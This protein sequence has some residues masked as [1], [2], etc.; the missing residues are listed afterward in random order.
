[1]QMQGCAAATPHTLCPP[2]STT[3]DRGTAHWLSRLQPTKI[4]LGL[5]SSVQDQAGFS[6][7]PRPTFV[8]V[9]TVGRA[10]GDL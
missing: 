4:K 7:I 8:H 1:M 5:G 9:R 10:G 3:S 6:S 2:G